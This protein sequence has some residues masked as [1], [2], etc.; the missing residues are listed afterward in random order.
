MSE[1][2]DAFLP[3]RRSLLSRL[4]NWDDQA[5]W[6]EFFNTYWK[7]IYATATRAGLSDAEAQDVVQETVISAAKQLP[8][9]RY[10][11]AAGS[12]KGWLRLITQRRIADHLRKAYRQPEFAAHGDPGTGATSEME[13]VPDPSSETPEVVW[14]EEW[15]R[16]LLAAALQ[17]VKRQVDA[18]HYQI[19][20]CYVLKQWPVKEVAKTFGV[21]AGQVYLIKHR[22][23]ALLEKETRKLES[24]G[25]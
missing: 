2:D 15:A 14:D 23:S 12:F 17:R 25:G 22:L 24:E 1:A 21:N 10:N 16:N 11:P 3:T 6:Q 7:L 18:K 9:F 20:D 19:F 13:R 5:S 4:R 8:Q